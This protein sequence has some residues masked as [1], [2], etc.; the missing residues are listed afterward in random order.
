MGQGFLEIPLV[1]QDLAQVRVDQCCAVL[2]SDA[3]V[4]RKGLGKQ[5][6]GFIKTAFHG[7]QDTEPARAVRSYPAISRA[8]DQV[9]ALQDQASGVAIIPRQSF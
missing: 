3:H 1:G 2:I 4:D 9:S 6:A 8:L 5:R 7:G